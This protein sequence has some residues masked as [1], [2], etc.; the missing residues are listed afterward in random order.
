MPDGTLETATTRYVYDKQ[1]RLLQTIGPDGSITRSE[2]DA[3]GQ[4][5]A[6]IDALGRR[7]SFEVDDLGRQVKI[8]HP[9]GF[10]EERV[11][12]GENRLLASKDRLGRTTTHVYDDTRGVC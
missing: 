6:T 12:D 11:Y 8:I 3:S 1:S 5:T 4:V 10:F 7:T 2:Y 9:D